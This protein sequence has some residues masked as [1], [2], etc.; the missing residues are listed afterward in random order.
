M[1]VL[2]GKIA[3][4][5]PSGDLSLV[6]V[7]CSGILIS[8]ILID[9]PDTATYLKV[10]MPVKLM[11]KETEVIIGL[12][13]THQISL[14]NKLDGPVTRIE[15]GELLSKITIQSEAGA[16]SSII[17]TNAVNQLGLEVGTLACAMIKTNEIMLSE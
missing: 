13:S 16:I 9:T 3:S 7:D 5:A 4:V 2:S 12:G 6:K 1:N 11:F 17:T 8:V 10:D 15:K 14:Q